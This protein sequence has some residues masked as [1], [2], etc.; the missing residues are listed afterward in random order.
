MP[1][2]N[3]TTDL[4]S[5][6]YGQDKPGGNSSG[7]PF[8][9]TNVDGAHETNFTI[10]GRNLLDLIG[11]NNITL[12]II[13]NIG[14]S[15]SRSKIGRIVNDVLS[16]DELIRG[17]ALGSVQAS[18]ND[19]F[20]IGSFF[21][22]LP[23]GP[24]FIAKQIGLQ[25]SN[26]KLE[27]K[28]GG[29]SA[30]S[31]LLTGNIGGALGTLTGGALGPTRIYNL[32]INTIAQVPVNAFGVHFNKHGLL[33][34]QNNDTKYESVAQYNNE[35]DKNRLVG[36]R[37]KF[38]LGDFSYEAANNFGK[39]KK[40]IDDE[41]KKLRKAYQ[42]DKQ[43][44]RKDVRSTRRINRDKVSMEQELMDTG[45][46]EGIS[47]PNAASLTR[48]TKPNYFKLNVAPHVVDQYLG[49]PGSIYGVGS[50]LI[51]R[52]SY[53]EDANK[54]NDAFANSKAFAG[55][56]RETTTSIDYAIKVSLD[57][58]KSILQYP[59]I[60]LLPDENI[61]K[62]ID[63]TSINVNK[64]TTSYYTL[65]ERIKKQST[66]TQFIP[67]SEV[68]GSLSSSYALSTYS[69]SITTVDPLV[70]R[71]LTDDSRYYGVRTKVANFL[72]TKNKYNNTDVF[73][74]T[75]AA[76]MSIIFRAVDPFG[77][78][79]ETWIF[80]AYMKGFKD[81]F[82]GTWNETNYVGRSES[83]YIYNKFKR[84]V[85]FNLSIPCFNKVE[86]FEK[87][88]ALGQLA[89]TTAGSYKN[90]FLGGVL[91]KL[92]VGNYLKGEYAILNSLSYDIPDDASWDIS[93]DAFLAMYLNASFNF[94]II[95][96]KRPEYIHSPATGT[97][98]NGFFGYLPDP[99]IPNSKDRYSGFITGQQVVD[100]FRKE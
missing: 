35:N 97:N 91:L 49:G 39:A 54:I 20:R 7:Q 95:H 82:T 27:V 31:D 51:R 5:L 86:L 59:G 79:T 83:F 30:I 75:D 88:R 92:N 99:Q 68:S 84:D 24:L 16:G 65:Y 3:L 66:Q 45:L 69:S 77:S 38:K 37:D 55:K 47:E 48:P 26:P 63:Q 22:S 23:K 76:L 87:H 85:S 62:A 80:P 8:I 4:K 14:A 28:K 19:T 44:Y 11:L 9:T 43:A 21:L 52:Y 50:T 94:T 71:G 25:F 57:A 42:D 74:R 29:I 61:V 17:G 1:L 33:P 89:S 96:I 98:T 32:G 81:N 72:G 56:A 2:V 34:I 18:I 46:D 60:N 41:N 90:N 73:A 13:P 15:L 10:P 58:D 6:K 40:E 36:Y 78:D 100:K 93:D 12:P 64:G 53:T 67:Y 70:S